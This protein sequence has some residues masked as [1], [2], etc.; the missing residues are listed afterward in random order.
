ALP[1]RKAVR[2]STRRH[3]G[4]QRWRRR[5]VGRGRGDNGR[6]TDNRGECQN[7]NEDD[8]ELHAVCWCCSIRRASSLVAT[9]WSGTRL[10]CATRRPSPRC[11]LRSQLC[12]ARVRRNNLARRGIAWGA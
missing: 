1:E 3:P 2:E 11:A 6:A 7:Q 10:P 12:S 9:T 4:K 5:G 8:K